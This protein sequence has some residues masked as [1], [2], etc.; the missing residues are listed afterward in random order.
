MTTHTTHDVLCNCGWGEIGMKACDIPNH[1]PMCGHDFWAMGGTPDCPCQGDKAEP[2]YCDVCG[3][4]GI[5]KATKVTL[6]EDGWVIANLVLCELC[7]D[8]S[9]EELGE[10]ALLTAARTAGRKTSHI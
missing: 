9:H 7:V 5:L 3:D 1:C 6:L 8:R 4:D 2:A 10:L